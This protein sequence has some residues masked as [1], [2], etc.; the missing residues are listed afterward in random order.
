MI[1]KIMIIFTEMKQI[2]PNINFNK[3]NYAQ[4]SQGSKESL[5]QCFAWGSRF[6]SVILLFSMKIL[7]ILVQAWQKSIIQLNRLNDY[8]IYFSNR[9]SSA[10]RLQCKGQVYIIS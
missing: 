2:H 4:S 8:K 3:N 9:Y 7:N 10:P 5:I 1:P 6:V